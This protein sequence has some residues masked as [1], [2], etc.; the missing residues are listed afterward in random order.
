[1]QI[2]KIHSATLWH[3][4]LILLTCS[5]VKIKLYLTEKE[6]LNYKS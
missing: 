3:L 5:S 1:M 2:F 4:A 6:Q